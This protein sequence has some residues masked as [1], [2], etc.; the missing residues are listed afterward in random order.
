M[1]EEDYDLYPVAEVI[2]RAEG[3]ASASLLQRRLKIGYLRA[4]KL[5]ERLEKN[6]VVERDE[7]PVKPYRLISQP[8]PSKSNKTKRT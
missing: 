3:K 4:V 7:N 5:L 2:V 1:I 8:N 6:G